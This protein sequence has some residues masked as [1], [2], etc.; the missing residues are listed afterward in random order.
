M[1]L[2]APLLAFF[3]T[4]NQVPQRTPQEAFE[5]IAKRADVARSAD[6][7]NDAIELYREGVRL[8]PSW[9]EGW[10]SLGS[11][12]YDEDRFSEA[13][14]AFKRFAAIA[15]KPG[16]AYAFLGLCEYETQ[17]YDRA[18]QHFRLWARAGWAGTPELL[19]VAVFHFA[20]L[21]TREG[22]FLEAL[23]L[24]ATEEGKKGSNPALVE[25]MGLASLRMKSVPEDYPPQRR[26][27]VWLAGEAA[28]RASSYPRD[29]ARV[30]EYAR[31]L[32]SRYDREPNV[33]AFRGSL[34][35]FEHKDSEAG[36]EFR[37]ELEISPEHVPAMVEIARMDV[38]NNQLVEAMTLAKRAAEMEPKNAEARH[39]LGQVFFATKQFRESVQELETAKQLA[40][41]SAPI[42]IH[43]ARVYNA[44]GRKKE[45]E[46]EV[47]AI[48]LLKDKEQVLAPPQEKVAPQK[49]PE[50]PR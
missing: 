19:D 18:L 16:P 47:A 44:L 42:R 15:P 25:A 39:V 1:V 26:E 43:L 24:L 36:V 2:V 8:R 14:A 13:Q 3:L 40:P 50:R 49:E 33:H 35:S 29:F 23:Y 20:L 21:L 7:V 34:Y 31:R 6:R 32:L 45:A 11:L 10:W 22:R 17:D 9:S 5:T 4:S 37:R 28:L 38:S 12:L 48:R 46:Q 30:D 27:M 41:D